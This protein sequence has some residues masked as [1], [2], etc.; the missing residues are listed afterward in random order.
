MIC[1]T[2][3]FREEVKLCL[4]SMVFLIQEINLILQFCHSLFVYILLVLHTELFHVLATSVETTKPQYFIIS[5]L[6]LLRKFLNFI[7]D[8]KVVLDELLIFMSDLSCSFIGS[9]QLFSP[10]LVSDLG[11]ATHIL[12]HSRGSL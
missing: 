2:F 12:S 5:G 8:G 7:F 10:F 3:V 4:D 6:Y 1:D 11:T 9:S